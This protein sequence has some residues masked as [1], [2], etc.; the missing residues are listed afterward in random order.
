[1]FW[2]TK[3]AMTE[4]EF[5]CKYKALEE[6][7]NS[8]G[9]ENPIV[10]TYILSEKKTSVEELEPRLDEMKQKLFKYF[11]TLYKKTHP[12]W[13]DYHRHQVFHCGKFTTQFVESINAMLDKMGVNGSSS[14]G[15]MVTELFKFEERQEF[16]TKFKSTRSNISRIRRNNLTNGTISL[17]GT[18]ISFIDTQLTSHGKDLQYFELHQSVDFKVVTWACQNNAYTANIEHVNDRK[19]Y[20]MITVDNGSKYHCSRCEHSIGNGIVCRHYLCMIR[21]GLS[22]TEVNSAFP[23][24]ALYVHDQW[25]LNGLCKVATN[26]TEL[27]Y[28]LVREHNIGAK[29][30][31]V[32]FNPLIE[33]VQKSNQVLKDSAGSIIDEEE[34]CTMTLDYDSDTDKRVTHAYA[35][36]REQFM[37]K[38]SDLFDHVIVPRKADIIILDT[39]S[40]KFV[41]AVMLHTTH[42]VT[43]ATTNNFNR[44]SRGLAPAKAAAKSLKNAFHIDSKGTSS[45][46]YRARIEQ[47]VQKVTEQQRMTADNSQQRQ[48]A[49]D[50]DEEEDEEEVEEHEGES[51]RESIAPM[52]SISQEQSQA[53]EVERSHSRYSLRTVLKSKI[54]DDPYK[55]NIG[56]FGQ[57]R[58]KI[59]K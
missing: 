58:K 12:R 3:E 53:I 15:Q 33:R 47:K 38:M 35:V 44:G 5:D 50:D 26:M 13:A 40:D 29:V 25:Y 22:N 17:F 39:L 51:N 49:S 18:F 14:V 46:N 41:E 4:S 27:I 48:G 20:T 10:K 8:I 21:E 11:I 52:V 19:L 57:S 32:E 34:I 1:M 30:T 31:F 55:A 28:P 43:A 16:N 56:W 37:K 42:I 59:R 23:I 36:Y 9:L 24:H 6:Y 2:D 45:N 7:I 54:N